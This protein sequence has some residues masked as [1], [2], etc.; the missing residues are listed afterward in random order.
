MEGVADARR[1]DED[2][3]TIPQMETGCDLLT[4]IAR[5][6]GPAPLH[7]RN[8]LVVRAQID[9]LVPRLTRWR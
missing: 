4:A 6:A 8:D 3:I 5:A 1:D 7:R 2:L 9:A